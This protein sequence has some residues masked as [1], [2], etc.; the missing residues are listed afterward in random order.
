MLLA[1][2]FA[3]DRGLR[4]SGS[5][6]NSSSRLL[7]AAIVAILFYSAGTTGTGGDSRVDRGGCCDG[8]DL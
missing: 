7:F 6:G 8:D 3:R 5:S 4:D 1:I 2:R